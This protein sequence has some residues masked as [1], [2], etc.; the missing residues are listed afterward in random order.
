MNGKIVLSLFGLT[1]V[2]ATM[3]AVLRFAASAT[4][5]TEPELPNN[6]IVECSLS[7]GSGSLGKHVELRITDQKLLRDLIDEPLRK[8]RVDPDP[9]RYVPVCSVRLVFKD[10]SRDGF[11]MF[12]PWGHYKRKNNYMIAQFDKLKME[13]KRSLDQASA[14]LR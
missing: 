1:V 5:S 12:E 7:L 8:A 13:F 11:V 14:E 4:G 6:A 3:V 9:A 2:S 10:G